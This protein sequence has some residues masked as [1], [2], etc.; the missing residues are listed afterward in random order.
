[1]YPIN[2]AASHPVDPHPTTEYSQGGH[3]CETIYRPRGK[4]SFLLFVTGS[5]KSFDR[6]PSLSVSNLFVVVTLEPLTYVWVSHYL[7][8][9][10]LFNVFEV[11]RRFG[12]GREIGIMAVHKGI[13]FANSQFC[14]ECSDSDHTFR[15]AIPLSLHSYGVAT[16]SGIYPLYMSIETYSSPRVFVV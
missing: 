10:G 15:T 12:F 4:D 7:G 14:D 6:Y 11:T 13:P 8:S 16:F 5:Y 2:N 9:Q 3:V 1:M